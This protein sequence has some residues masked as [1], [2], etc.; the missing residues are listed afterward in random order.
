LSYSSMIFWYIPRMK[1]SMLSI[2]S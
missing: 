1:K 2:Y